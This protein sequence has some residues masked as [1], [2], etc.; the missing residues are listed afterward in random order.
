MTKPLEC[1]PGVRES[2]LESVE[3]V[4]GSRESPVARSLASTRSRPPGCATFSA[5]PRRS[6]T[7]RRV[8]ESTRPACPRTRSFF[9]LPAEVAGGLD[10]M[11]DDSPGR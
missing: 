7:Q 3:R 6:S 11:E 8:G 5:T 1:L 2:R 10:P 9:V 4:G